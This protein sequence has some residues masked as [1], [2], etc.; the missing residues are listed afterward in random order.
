MYILAALPRRKQLSS[1]EF[2]GTWDWS[3]QH[4]C[5]LVPEGVDRGYEEG[6]PV[7]GYCRSAHKQLLN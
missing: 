7:K 1:G 5:R 6:G 2:I 4:D 3:K